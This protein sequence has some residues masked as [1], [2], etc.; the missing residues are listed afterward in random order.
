MV[1]SSMGATDSDKES[2]IARWVFAL[3]LRSP[4]DPVM[5]LAQL[6]CAC[7]KRLISS[8]CLAFH[9][10]ATAVPRE[11]PRT[12]FARLAISKS[13]HLFSRSSSVQYLNPMPRAASAL[14]PSHPSFEI[15]ETLNLNKRLYSLANAARFSAHRRHGALLIRIE[16]VFL[17]ASAAPRAN[18]LLSILSSAC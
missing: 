5:F 1:I 8:V 6:G 2:V 18:R 4:H 9:L 3:M 11:Y 17:V 7:C 16:R 13:P 14:T 12:S 15:Q 10:S